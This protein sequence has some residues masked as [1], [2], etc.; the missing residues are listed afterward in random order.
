VAL[1]AVGVVL[2]VFLAATAWLF[3]WP[4]RGMP[5]RVD[6]IVMMAGPGNRLAEALRL[7]RE[8]RAPFLVISKGFDGYGGPCPQPIRGVKLTCFNPDPASTRGEAEFAG[9][10]ARRYHWDSIVLVTSIPQDWRARQRMQH[11]FRGSVY[12]MTVGIPWYSWPYEIAYEWGAT[13]KMLAF[14]P[15]C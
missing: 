14:Q 15:N 6:A 11:C 12:S 10:L 9:R 7:A 5:A 8:H 1:S 3:V 13:I 2:V 4:A